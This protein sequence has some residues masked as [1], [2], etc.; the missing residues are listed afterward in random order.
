MNYMEIYPSNEISSFIK[1]FWKYENRDSDI[2]HTIFPN[3]YFELFMIFEKQKLES[4][5]LSGLRTRPF[6]VYV[7]KGIVVS[8]IRFMLPASEYIFE[9]KIS[10]ILDTT[11]SLDPYFWDLKELEDLSFE[12]RALDVFQKLSGEIKEKEIN[13]KKLSLLEMAYNPDLTV[14]EISERI[15][16]DRRKINRYFNTRYGLPLKTFLDIIRL[17]SSFDA[18]KEGVLYPGLGYY[19]Q[20]HYI[21]EVKKYT[22]ESPKKLSKNESDRFLQFSVKKKS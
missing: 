21:K 11:M 17:R 10:S 1:C 19:D 20:S 4:V 16:W 5:F 18:L 8:A 3:G 22:G 12:D 2:Q 6:E 9:R 15:H 13:K 14:K 7:P